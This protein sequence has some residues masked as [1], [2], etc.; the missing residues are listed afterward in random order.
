MCVGSQSNFANL[1]M[2]NYALAYIASR[3]K[4]LGFKVYSF[5]PYLIVLN[6]N[7]LQYDIIGTNEYFYLVSKELPLGTEIMADNN[8]F[9]VWDYFTYMQVSGV[10]EFFGNIH[11]SI[12]AGSNQ[13]I[14]EFIR[15][16]PDYS[17]V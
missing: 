11:V 15:V 5:E 1:I 4:Q 6:N 8:F 9:Q 16:I 2:D 3:M 17:I 13:Q 12:P 10:Q 14:F 7:K